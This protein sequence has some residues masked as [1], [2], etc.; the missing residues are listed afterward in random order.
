MDLVQH[1]E[2]DTV[3][4]NSP[5]YWKSKPKYAHRSNFTHGGIRVVIDGD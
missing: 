1:V 5:D 2:S 3:A 4:G